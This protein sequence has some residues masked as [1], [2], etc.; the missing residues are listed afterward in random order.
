[1]KR[2]PNRGYTAALCCLL[3][4]FWTGCIKSTVD[5]PS[6][7]ES[8]EESME[9]STEEPMGTDLKGQ[10]QETQNP[11]AKWEESPQNQTGRPENRVTDELGYE[12]YSYDRQYTADDGTVIFQTRLSYPHFLGRQEGVSA[13]NRYFEEWA[14]GKAEEYETQEDSMRQSALEVYR[15]SRDIGWPGPWSEDYEVTSVKEKAGYLSVLQDSYLYEG[16]AHG[17]PYREGHVFRIQDGQPVTLEQMTGLTREDWDKLLRA[18]FATLISQDRDTGFYEDAA[19]QIKTY[20][21]K[22]AD[23]YFSDEGIVFY[24]PPYEIAPYAAGYVE[25]LIPYDEAQI[26]AANG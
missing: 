11:S 4:F 21:M 18:R 25:V 9:K 8:M 7:E 17:M 13:I 14:S 16:G 5:P 12:I 19:E 10:E 22:K 6:T 2:T 23:Y 26:K 24:L 15:E 3:A 1:M 20:D